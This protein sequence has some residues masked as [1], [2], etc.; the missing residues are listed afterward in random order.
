MK[1]SEELKNKLAYKTTE[2]YLAVYLCAKEFQLVKTEKSSENDNKVLFVFEDTAKLKEAINKYYDGSALVL[3]KKFKYA[4]R[5]L[6]S[7]LYKN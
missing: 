4:I 2:F 3:V 6:K 1:K 7:Q 5:D